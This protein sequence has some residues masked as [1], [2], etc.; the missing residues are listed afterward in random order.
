MRK[1]TVVLDCRWLGPGGAGRVTEL[2]LRDL[3]A[4]KPAWDVI[5]YGSPEALRPF[6]LPSAT[7]VESRIDPKWMFGQRAAWSLPTGDVT[8]FFHQI[9]PIVRGRTITLMYDTIPLRYGSSR[10]AR[11][12]KRLYYRIVA[13]RS[14]AIITISEHS[15]GCLIR[16][17]GVDAARISIA[18]LPV[19][20]ERFDAIARSRASRRQDDVALFVGR[21]AA[22]KN[23]PRL[24]LAFG[25]SRFAAEGGQL[26]LVGG[27][28]S[29]RTEV[30]RFLAKAGVVGV[31]G[32]GP[33]SEAAL[34]SWFARARLVVLPSLEEGFG[35]PAFEAAAAGIPVVTSRAGAMAQLPEDVASFC[36]PLDVGSIAS[37]ID[38]AASAPSPATF[39]RR[40]GNL[41]SVLVDAVESVLAGSRAAP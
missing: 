34:D 39:Y 8:I 36:D 10:V 1:P 27:T 16:D 25:Q 15:R 33:C 22:H 6:R 17:T 18:E 32:H 41:G 13:A 35:L 28:A 38:A 5:L 12:V 19:D 21:F 14:D 30:E 29:E 9:R 3:E 26:H 24:A 40:P 20:G 23:I 11:V 37:M 7:L 2:A 31:T 4:I